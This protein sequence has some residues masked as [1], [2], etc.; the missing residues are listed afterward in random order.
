LGA[1]PCDNV[2]RDEID[3]VQLC[4]KSLIL[5]KNCWNKDIMIREATVRGYAQ[6]VNASYLH[7]KNYRHQ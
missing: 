4:I 5:G 2:G 3:L 1:D 7:Y 6:Q